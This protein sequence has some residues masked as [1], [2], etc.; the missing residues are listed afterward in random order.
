MDK[1][2]FDSLKLGNYQTLNALLN[3]S[4]FSLLRNCKSEE[5]DFTEGGREFHRRGAEFWKARSPY[6]T[7]LVRGTTRSMSNKMT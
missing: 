7:V 1:D 2:T 3:N 5:L 4:V 6:L